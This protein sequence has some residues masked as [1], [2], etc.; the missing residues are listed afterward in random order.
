M[1]TKKIN[2]RAE[3]QGEL[4]DELLNAARLDFKGNKTRLN[5]F[6][7]MPANFVPSA[8]SRWAGQKFKHRVPST[9]E[10]Y[11]AVDD[12]W[13]KRLVVLG[14]TQC[15]K[16]TFVEGLIG[17]K[18][19]SCNHGIGVYYP[20]E[21][22]QKTFMV[23]IP[24]M[25]RS[26]ESDRV[27]PAFKGEAKLQSR[28]LPNGYNVEFLN[29]ASLATAH[30]RTFGTAICDEWRLHVR[31]IATNM[32]SRVST[33]G[34]E[35][36]LVFVSSAGDAG[37]CKT[38]QDFLLGTAEVWQVPCPH[39]ETYQE[40]VWANV[41]F[42][43]M[44]AESARYSCQKC[45]RDIS[46]EALTDSQQHGRYHQTNKN[47]LPNQRSFKFNA[48]SDTLTTLQE[49]VATYI[50]AR[51]KA[52]QDGDFEKIK[53][54][55]Q[56]RMVE[57]E[58]FHEENLSPTAVQKAH[59][60]KNKMPIDTV[61]IY[62]DFITMAVDLQ[63]DRFE[64]EIVAWGLDRVESHEFLPHA[65][66]RFINY[67]AFTVDDAILAP[68]RFG[69]AYFQIPLP[70]SSADG[71]AKIVNI[72][73]NWEFKIDGFGGRKIGIAACAIDIGDGNF[74]AEHCNFFKNNTDKY[75]PIKGSGKQDDSIIYEGKITSEFAKEV[76]REFF[77]IGTHACKQ[78]VKRT[79]EDGVESKD[80]RKFEYG[81]A[82]K[83]DYHPY[84]DIIIN[85]D[86]R[87]YTDEYF[88]G[89]TRSEK[90][91]KAVDKYGRIKHVWDRNKNIPNE[92]FDLAV[93]NFALLKLFLPTAWENHLILQPSRE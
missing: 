21:A 69:V 67:G 7:W 71:W 30:A 89:L 56:D 6:D 72:V 70:P 44:D 65:N 16:S 38:T 48:L 1:L 34:K 52:M 15:F 49:L 24:K 36:L 46:P 77:F 51:K 26:C 61:P 2:S 42:D 50:I 32:E 58:N 43:E 23:R 81:N 35:A 59:T 5:F 57:S 78:W 91:V 55:H 31:D 29:S 19:D 14:P 83:R 18:A 12:G 60:A 76:G 25:L 9:F 39:C 4:L 84:N 86:L 68:R 45:K 10:I 54:F 75:V 63:Q 22:T 79:L 64:C 33:Y 40:L 66:R 28:L 73:E 3:Y 90:M 27:A 62:T 80:G 8:P 74:I 47:P 13:T 88:K 85:H 11:R 93:Y 41:K 92:P 20:D 17:Y 37:M 82:Y 87:G 53:N